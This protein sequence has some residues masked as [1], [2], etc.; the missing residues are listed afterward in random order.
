LLPLLKAGGAGCITATSNLVANSLR[1][2]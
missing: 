2:V 1:T